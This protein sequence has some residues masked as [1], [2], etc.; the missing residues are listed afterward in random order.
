MNI[1]LK[2]NRFKIF[3]G[4]L[5]AIAFTFP[6]IGYLCVFTEPLLD[7]LQ[8]LSLKEIILFGGTTVVCFVGLCLLLISIIFMLFKIFAPAKI[9]ITQEGINGRITKGIVFWDEIENIDYFSL[10]KSGK[11]ILFVLGAIMSLASV[12]AL[13]YYVRAILLLNNNNTL[14]IIR[15]TLKNKTEILLDI[16]ECFVDGPHTV[17]HIINS[18]KIAQVRGSYYLEQKLQE[19]GF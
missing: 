9:T 5:I 19:L 15:L 4:L 6:L 8:E 11:S 18:Y 2:E 14:G 17:L 16:D 13:I 3:I 10:R 1:E 12:S 7:R